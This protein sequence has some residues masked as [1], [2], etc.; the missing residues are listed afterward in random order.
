MADR[1][2]DLRPGGAGARNPTG[3]EPEAERPDLEGARSTAEDVGALPVPRWV[4]MQKGEKLPP[5][6]GAP[7]DTERG[8]LPGARRPMR[9]ARPAPPR[10]GLGPTVPREEE[11]QFRRSVPRAARTPE[12]LGRALSRIGET[13][14]RDPQRGREAGPPLPGED[15][16]HGE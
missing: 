13:G 2:E 10:T 5:T 8:L 14:V 6:E 1:L 11:A 16:Y 12:E 3:S 9:P 7:F 4:R 15:G